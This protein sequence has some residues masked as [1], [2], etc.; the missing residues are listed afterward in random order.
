MLRAENGSLEKGSYSAVRG[1]SSSAGPR[2]DVV[3]GKFHLPPMTG[4]RSCRSLVNGIERRNRILSTNS[5]WRI[6]CILPFTTIILIQFH[7]F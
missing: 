5:G 4:Q 7:P 6:Y 3:V 2:K 1:R